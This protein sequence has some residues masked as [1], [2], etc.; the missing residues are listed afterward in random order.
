MK[1]ID[2][3]IDNNLGQLRGVR[4]ICVSAATGHQL[5]ILLDEILKVYDRWNTRVTTAQINDWLQKMKKTQNLPTA[6]GESLK[7]RFMAQVKTR[8][9]S[10]VLFVNDT[11]LVKE[12][13]FRYLRQQI[14]HEFGL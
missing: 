7:I 9:P 13:Y 1:Y 12:N 6:D 3:Q 8:P 10:F 14:T 11:T 4:L 2:R 5:D